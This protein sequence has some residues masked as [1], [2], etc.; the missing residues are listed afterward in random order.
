MI[1]PALLKTCLQ[2][3]ENGSQKYENQHYFFIGITKSVNNYSKIPQSVNI[4]LI[5]LW[6]SRISKGNW[7]ENTT[8][9]SEIT[10]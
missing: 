10:Q 4:K 2:K 9:N 6:S 1:T 7:C 8:T 5:D 3:S